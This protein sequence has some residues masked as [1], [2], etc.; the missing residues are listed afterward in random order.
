[1]MP[2]PVSELLLQAGARVRT[3]EEPEKIEYALTIDGAERFYEARVVGCDGDKIL[4]IVRDV[5]EQK[6]AQMEAAAQRLELAHL[7]RVAVL[8]ELTG[9]LAHELSQP[10]TAVLSN[11]QA[12][13]AFWIASRSMCRSYE[14]P[15]TTSSTTPDGP[16][17]SSTGCAR[18]C[19]SKPSCFSR[20]T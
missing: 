7:S 6:T 10:L 2:A 14:P 15:S 12:A 9:A 20:S 11:A 3:A 1:M 13:R 17:P 4:S 16:V 8:G 18:C 5:T 19:G